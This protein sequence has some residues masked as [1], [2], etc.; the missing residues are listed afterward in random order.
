MRDIA[1]YYHIVVFFRGEYLFITSVNNTNRTF[2]CDKN[3]EPKVFKKK[4]AEDMLYYV[5]NNCFDAYLV[6]AFYSP[7]EKQ[8]FAKKSSVECKVLLSNGN[9]LTM[10]FADT[11]EF[12]EGCDAS[13]DYDLYP[14][15]E[16]C[17]AETNVI[18]GGQY[19][20]DSKKNNYADIKE[21]I[22]DVLF[23]I[24]VSDDLPTYRIIE[25]A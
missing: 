23:C 11:D 12:C 8:F 14:S 7:V 13:I 24:Y 16:D 18:D 20:Y 15:L 22:D 3:A 21:A 2:F 17:K 5:K 10:H 4:Q 9:V 6:E 19:D 1:K 25:E